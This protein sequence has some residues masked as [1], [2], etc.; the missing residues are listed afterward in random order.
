MIPEQVTVVWEVDV[1]M[2]QREPPEGYV[3]FRYSD[4]RD[5]SGY[6]RD[7]VPEG[8]GVMRGPVLSYIGIWRGGTM[9]EGLMVDTVRSTEFHIPWA[10]TSPEEERSPDPQ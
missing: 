4:G 3:V 10:P 5:Y 2:G 6:M 1:F 7:G 9:I 8:Y